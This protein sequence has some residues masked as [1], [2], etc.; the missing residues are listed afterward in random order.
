MRAAEKLKNSLWG[1]NLNTVLETISV[2]GDTWKYVPKEWMRTVELLWLG[3]DERGG[4]LIRPEDVDALEKD[5]FRSEVALELGCGGIIVTGQPGI[6]ALSSLIIDRPFLNANPGKT[7]FLYYLLFRRLSE[8][9]PVALQRNEHIFVFQDHGVDR[10]PTNAQSHFLPNGTW[11]LL[12]PTKKP[13]NLV[14][15][16]WLLLRPQGLRAWIV[17]TTSPLEDRWKTWEKY[18]TADMFV[19]KSFSISEMTALGFD[20]LSARVSCSLKHSLQH[21]AQPQPEQSPTQLQKVGSF[22]AHLC[23]VITGAQPGN[24]A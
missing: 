10:Y 8:Q 15:P 3:L 6:G 4:F 23:A 12:T 21:S 5:V 24:A 9:K 17:Q 13:H 11:A 20:L 22:S 18:R 14:L 19:M 16:F 2:E 7:C 1:I